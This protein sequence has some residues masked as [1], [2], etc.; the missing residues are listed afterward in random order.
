MDKRERLEATLVGDLLDRVPVALWRYWP[1]DDQRAADFAR[2]T[3][4][5]QSAY[6]W[7]FVNVSPF[8]AYCVADYGVQTE[9]QGDASGNRVIIKYPVKR[10]LSWT[11]L[12]LDQ[13]AANW[14]NIWKRSG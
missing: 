9:W 10:S 2:S 1:G 6:D 3:V 14:A 12:A 4:E 8:S 5:F 13:C 7:D 11:E